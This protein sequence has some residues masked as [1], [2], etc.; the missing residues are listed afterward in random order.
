VVLF[1]PAWGAFLGLLLAIAEKAG[2]HFGGS[3]VAGTIYAGLFAFLACAGFCAGLVAA[4][5]AWVAMR[6]GVK[7]RYVLVTLAALLLGASAQAFFNMHAELIGCEVPVLVGATLLRGGLIG[8]AT[9]VFAV[10][11]ALAAPYFSAALSVSAL[12]A[13]TG[14]AAARLFPADR[15]LNGLSLPLM[16]LLAATLTVRLARRRIWAYAVV[17]L[18]MPSAFFLVGAAT[19]GPPEPVLADVA[20]IGADREAM[21]GGRP[22]VLVVMLDTLRPDHVSFN[23]YDSNTTPRLDEFLRQATV[24]SNAKS[25]SSWT[26]PAHGSLFT[27]LWPQSHGARFADKALATG[28]PNVS[29]IAYPLNRNVPTLA[30]TMRSQG[31]YTAAIVSNYACLNGYFGLQR[32]FDHYFC[33][34]RYRQSTIGEHEQLLMSPLLERLLHRFDR[35]MKG[36]FSLVQSY[37]RA[38]EITA[39]TSAWLARNRE[40]RFLLFLNYQDPHSPYNAPAPY[41]EFFPGRSGPRGRELKWSLGTREV[42]TG[43]QTLGQRERENFISQ[44]DGEVAYLDHWLGRLFDRMKTLGLYD[45]CLIVVLS[46]H[47]ESFGEHGVMEHGVTLYED[48]VAMLLAVKY[49]GQREGLIKDSLVQIHDLMPTILAE[50]NI[51]LPAA[52]DGQHLDEVTHPIVST[53]GLHI[54]RI[55]TYGKRFDRKLQAIYGEN[56]KVIRSSEGGIEAYD[57]RS[58]SVEMNGLAVNAE[59]VSLLERLDG[60][61]RDHPEVPPEIHPEADRATLERLKSL[62]YL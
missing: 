16:G 11:T 29:A 6:L 23:G 38:P 35:S 24:Y 43:E 12:G 40:K 52:V 37:Y 30:E 59:A 32:G 58:E 25:V 61:Q 14:I 27:G 45:D 4:V 48:Q 21:V 53:L 13:L 31:Y 62:G 9:F 50:L 10:L 54:G 18:I 8:A 7:A 17:A 51:P 42:M 19:G 33:A 49:P 56:L 47:G 15:V 1:L 41:D 44:Y 20:P 55:E 60:W 2:L 26:L 28:D 46:D 39:M 22:N 57:F 3:E 5:I 34:A 36:N